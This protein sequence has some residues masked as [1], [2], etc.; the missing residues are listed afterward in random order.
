MTQRRD[1]R[2][3]APDAH[4]ADAVRRT[5]SRV[6]SVNFAQQSAAP[7]D[8]LRSAPISS[9]SR[10][11]WILYCRRCLSLS[12][13]AALETRAVRE[14]VRP[15]E[16]KV[17]RPTTTTVTYMLSG[18]CVRSRRRSLS[19]RAGSFPVLVGWQRHLVWRL[20]TESGSAHEQATDEYVV[21]SKNSETVHDHC[22]Q[23]KEARGREL[24]MW[25][26]SMF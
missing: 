11:P 20:V 24:V 15:R 25:S 2:R 4:E 1:V 21:V 18:V 5:T 6:S 10:R 9:R 7:L 19:A 23:R 17:T 22:R 12:F 16:V 8:L 3:D 14:T 13:I 26:R